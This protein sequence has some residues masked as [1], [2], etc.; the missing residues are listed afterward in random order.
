[1]LPFDA[2]SKNASERDG[3]QFRCKKC[4]AIYYANNKIQIINKVKQYALK[5]K[6]DKAKYDKNYRIRNAKKLA[7]YE[8]TR[9]KLPHRRLL[10][11]KWAAKNSEKRKFIKR[12]SYLKHAAA[13]YIRNRHLY[14]AAA[15]RR[16]LAIK[17][18]NFAGQTE[19]DLFV[20]DEAALLAQFRQTTTGIKWEIDHI[21]PIK[22]KLACGLNTAHNI[23]VIP[24]NVNRKKGARNMNQYACGYTLL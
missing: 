2:F 22:H 17:Q 16:R 4:V 12:K 8:K 11:Y 7:L 24:K 9:S 20:F 18:T 13:S 21:V 1:M 14:M 15:H 6:E 19:L 3:L 23:Q 10:V 5:H